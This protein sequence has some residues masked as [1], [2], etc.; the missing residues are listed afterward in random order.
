MRTFRRILAMALTISA[1]LTPQPIFAGKVKAYAGRDIDLTRYKTYEW[2]P[3]RVLTKAGVVEDHPANPILK[4][5]VGRQLSQRGLNEV[6]D[7]AEL[8]IQ[9][10]VL[11][12]SVPQIEAVILAAAPGG[13][14]FSTGAPLATV[15]RYN[16]EGS[17]YVSLIDRQTKAGVWLGMAT[18]SLPNGTIDEDEIRAKVNKAATNIFKKYPVKKK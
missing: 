2:F 9:I 16:R 11:T 1:C 6:A 15:G 18:D 10:W 13:D 4:E 7:G 8:Q 17:L 5:E 12:Q 3:P 14:V